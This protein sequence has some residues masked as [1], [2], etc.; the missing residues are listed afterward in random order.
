MAQTKPRASDDSLVGATL[1][2]NQLPVMSSDDRENIQHS[3]V[4]QPH[5][6]CIQ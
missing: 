4:G 1:A 2:D 5:L 6:W 3:A